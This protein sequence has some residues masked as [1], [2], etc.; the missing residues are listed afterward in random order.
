MVDPIGSRVLQY[1]TGGSF[2]GSSPLSGSS[3]DG[4]A[5]DPT[6]NTYFCYDSGTD[7]VREYDANFNQIK[8]FP[9]TVSNG[10][11]AG[12]GVAV[13]RRLAALFVA[14][15]N[16]NSIVEFTIEI[17]L[18]PPAP[19]F[20]LCVQ[21]DDRSRYIAFNSTTRRYIYEDCLKKITIEGTGIINRFSCKTFFFDN[22]LDPK[23]P[24]RLIPDR[25]VNVTINT[26]TRKGEAQIVL[27][28][29]LTRLNDNNISNNT[30]RCD[31]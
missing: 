23:H 3:Q 9:G 5:Y 11:G 6:N 4:I 14:V 22:G 15:P 30:C 17:Q 2:L 24:D 18:R 31:R 12:E 26:C 13:S 16:N 29:R 28:N 19:E 1:T 10:F 25:L 20:D 7:M 27:N 21:T 8:S